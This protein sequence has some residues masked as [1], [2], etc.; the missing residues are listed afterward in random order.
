MGGI[1]QVTETV[2]IGAGMEVTK[3]KVKLCKNIHRKK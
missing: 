1:L 2:M 3:K